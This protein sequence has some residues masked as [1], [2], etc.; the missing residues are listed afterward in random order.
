[1]ESV[2]AVRIAIAPSL[3]AWRP[4]INWAW[5]LVLST[6]GWAW[7][8]VPP[9]A[10]CDILYAPQGEDAGAAALVVRAEPAL[11]AAWPRLT[12]V[13]R[14]G[15]LCLPLYAGMQTRADGWQVEST[16][17]RHSVTAQ[18]DLLF[19]LFWLATGGAEQGLPL[20][21]NDNLLLPAPDAPQR[22]LWLEAAA[23]TILAWF[24]ETGLRLGWPPPAP[25]W[26]NGFV[27]AA[28]AGHDV[29]YPELFRWLEPARVLARQG[30]RGLAPALE[31]VTGRRH[32]WHF[33]DWMELEQGLGSRSAFY[34]VARKG[35]LLE[36]ARGL[37]D[38]FYDVQSPRFRALFAALADAGFEVGLHASYLAYRSVDTLRAEKERLEEAAGRPVLGNRHHYWHMQPGAPDDTLLL[39]EQAGLHYDTSLTNDRYLGWRRGLAVPYTPFHRGRR[40]AVATLQIGTA[41]MDDHLV[42]S[43]AHNPGDPEALL[44]GLAE[45]TRRLGGCLLVDVHDYVYDDR[46]YPGWRAAYVSLWNHL[47]TLGGFWF[48]TPA[49]IAEFWRC[50]AERIAHAAVGLT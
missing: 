37:P 21:A 4:E 47:R 18:R 50:R 1:M 42:G 3:E 16:A 11:W 40:R 36:Y 38:P 49:E 39:H 22:T 6:A 24:E 2:A 28:A 25:R 44:R 10:P 43:A 20:D 14:A 32:H 27:A 26:P 41:W 23:S 5:R 9:G 31:V 30:V 8:E 19:D 46:L 7:R 34:F 33:A 29:D 13:A 48:A 17:P 12:G 15:A 45:R 35:S